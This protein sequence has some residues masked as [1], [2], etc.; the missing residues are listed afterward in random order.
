VQSI[1]RVQFVLCGNGESVDHLRSAVRGNRDILFPGWVDA[2]QIWSLMARAS[3]GLA[4]YVASPN[5]VKNLA[6]KPIEYLAGGLPILNS[7]SEG[8]LFN[9]VQQQGCGFSYAGS[10]SKLSE[11]ILSGL[12]TPQLHATL[13]ANARRVFARDFDSNRVYSRMLAH[14]EDLARSFSASYSP[15]RAAG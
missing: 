7:L 12:E 1:R 10:A 14:L 5:F 15:T 8:P 4:P 9:L 2:H 11:A 6:N 13:R 3:F